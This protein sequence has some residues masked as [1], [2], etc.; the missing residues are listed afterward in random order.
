MALSNEWPYLLK[1]PYLVSDSPIHLS[2][3]GISGRVAY[4]FGD[5]AGSHLPYLECFQRI[6]LLSS[7]TWTLLFSVLKCIW[8]T[9]DLLGC[10]DG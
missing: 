2:N 6:R 1:Q 7:Y 4:F 8:L 5:P 3:L 10:R 9:V